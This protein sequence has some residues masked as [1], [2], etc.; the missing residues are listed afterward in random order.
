MLSDMLSMLSHGYFERCPSSR[1]KLDD[2][3]V[4]SYIIEDDH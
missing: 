1:A 3:V 2:D 4:L